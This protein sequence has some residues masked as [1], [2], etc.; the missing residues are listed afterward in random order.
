MVEETIIFLTMMVSWTISEKGNDGHWDHYKG[1]LQGVNIKMLDADCAIITG[2]THPICQDYA[3]AEAKG[4][5]GFALVCDG[6]SAA[7]MSDLGARLLA[8]SARAHREL[9][10]G[11]DLEQSACA[12]AMAAIAAAR[13]SLPPFASPRCLDATL[14][15]GVVREER[16]RLVLFG[17]GFALWGDKDDPC[18]LGVEYAGGAPGYPAYLLEKKRAQAFAALSENAARL[19]GVEEGPLEPLRPV[20][21]EIRLDP[22]EAL[23]LASDGLGQF[24]GPRAPSAFELYG[25]VIAFRPAPGS[26]VQ[27]R[28]R[29]GLLAPLARRGVRP[30][31]DL[32]VAALRRREG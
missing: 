30:M 13:A 11:K 12:F 2:A 19:F 26:F 15:A 31:D 16:A 6:C 29:N 8:L 7:P 24:A 28:L 20:A 21:R 22:G 5:E 9:L 14:L 3:L 17:D 32:A 18:V 10:W 27:R 1:H 4:A 25:E 23:V